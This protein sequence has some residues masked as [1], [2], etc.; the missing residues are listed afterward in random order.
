[1]GEGQSNLGGGGVVGEDLNS[2]GL[3]ATVFV[4]WCKCYSD[5]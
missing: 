4:F 5:H 2:S 1:M 3:K